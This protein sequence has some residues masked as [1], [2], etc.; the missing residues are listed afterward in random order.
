[1]DPI[2]RLPREDE[3]EEFLRAHR[4]TSPE[5]P[6]FLHYHVEGM[7]FRRYL[8]V[9]REQVLQ[10]PLDGVHLLFNR[11]W[12]FGPA[13]RLATT[14]PTTPGM[15]GMK[16]DKCGAMA[17]LGTM[18]AAA[19]LDLQLPLVGILAAS[20]PLDDLIDMAEI[21]FGHALRRLGYSFE[22]P[23]LLSPT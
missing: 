2:L 17:V 4:A 9:L 20:E 14:G 22:L 21:N 16:Y 8:E 11:G 3:E 15:V 5:V 23:I 1:M 10:Y 7:P 18:V 19:K 12:P 13:S 6:S